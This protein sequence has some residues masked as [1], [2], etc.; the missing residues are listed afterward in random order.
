MGI[1]CL[2]TALV[3][4]CS[5]WPDRTAS[6]MHLWLR[7]S[8]AIVSI[9]PLS[10]FARAHVLD[11]PWIVEIPAHGLLQSRLEGLARRPAA[12]RRQTGGVDGVA[13]VV[14]GAV[15]H[16]LD[17]PGQLLRGLVRLLRQD[18][19]DGV[20]DV[21]VLALAAPADVVGLAHAPLLDDRPDGLAVIV[22][23]QPVPHV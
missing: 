16:V 21:D 9:D 23:V 18:G 17:Q 22:D 1:S 10:I 15:R 13:L 2:L 4:G 19:A 11:P 20:H 8:F 14:A 5:R 6:T 12:L 7:G 3:N